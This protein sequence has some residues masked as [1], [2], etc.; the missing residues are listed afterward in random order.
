MIK[1]IVLFVLVFYYGLINS[2]NVDEVRK[3]IS[4]YDPEKYSQLEFSFHQNE[5][6]VRQKIYDFLSI[7]P[8]VSTDI[9]SNGRF[10]KLVDVINDKP[11]YVATDNFS[12]AVASRT[13]RLYPGGLLGLNLQGE[14]MNV[15]VWDSG[16]I[17]KTHVE[18]NTPSARV[19]TPDNLSITPTSNFHA[20]HVGGTVGAAG[21]VNSARGM[22]PR[23]NIRSYDWSGDLNEVL[24]DV[25]QNG[26]LISNHSYGVPIY[27][28]NNVLNV[29]VWYMGCYNDTAVAWDELAYTYP[30]YLMVASA[31]NSGN[32]SYT[33]GLAPGFD[34]LTGNKNSKNNLVVANANPSVHPI[35]GNITSLFIN[36]SSSQGPTDDGRI[37][38]DIAADGTNVFSTFNSN[39]NDYDTISGTSMASPVVSGTILLLQ[40]HYNNLYSNFMKAS[41]L[42]GLV[43]HTALDDTNI[44]GPD[45]RFG[46]GLLDAQA[47]ANVITSN[48]TG[49]SLIL[50]SNLVNGQT[51]TY[52]FNASSSTP[53]KATICWTDPQ[54]T[55]RNGLLNDATP[56]L[57]NDLDLRITNSSETFF[58]WKYDL[59]NLS[60]GAIKGD[61][62]VDNLERIDITS[63]TS[64]QYTLTVSHKG[65]LLSG[66][67][68][69]SLI[70]TGGDLVLNTIDS[71]IQ[72][73]KVWPNPANDFLN[74]NLTTSS[75][76]TF[77]TIYDIHGRIVF[78]KEVKNH[79][80]NHSIDLK[81]F[82]QGMYLLSVKSGLNSIIKKVLIN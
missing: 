62:N 73:V 33:G 47:A 65:T 49:G 79:E 3:I 37:K 68:A 77:I 35:T 11:V 10:Y 1:K 7:N 52:L 39:N 6:I 42:K 19:I 32:D 50:E 70:L 72:E 78:F 80:L 15:G 21:V 26:L 59:N 8:N 74:I 82:T 23:S 17:L 13:N 18:F 53:L 5:L 27:N 41:T 29:P 76:P 25:S 14:G 45:T 55:S 56:V 16:W 51:F 71:N 48:S 12:A 2:Q 44:I 64:G 54:G 75:D 24:F 36:G 40:E 57:V 81:N 34:K 46:W 43:C 67:Q 30:Y 69:F 58:P 63:P 66:N 60:G 61:N 20:T 4:E 31:G 38:P 28:D 9:E 22:A